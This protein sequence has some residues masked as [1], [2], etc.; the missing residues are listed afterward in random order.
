MGRK[1]WWPGRVRLATS[2]RQAR[3]YVTARFGIGC[4]LSELSQ[5]VGGIPCCW[6]HLDLLQIH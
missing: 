6:E 2:R 3:A 5:P 1:N 4:R